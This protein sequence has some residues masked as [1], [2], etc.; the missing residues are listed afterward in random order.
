MQADGHRVSLLDC[1][2][3]A[4]VS[5]ADTRIERADWVGFTATSLTYADARRLRMLITHKPAVIGGVHATLF[6][7]Q[8]LSD[9][10]QLVVVGEGEL[11]M[12]RVHPDCRGILRTVEL[13]DMDA[14]P[15]LPYEL[16]TG[17]HY[18]ATPLHGRNGTT[19]P[20]MSSRGCPWTC[21]FCSKAVFG[22]KF[23]FM[24]PERVV[25]EL[26]WLKRL[27]YREIAFYDDTFTIN[28]QRVA[29]LC[30]LMTPLG[31][32]WTCQARVNTVD[33]ELLRQMK[34]AGCHMIAY[35]I[36]SGVPELLAA[37]SKNITHEQVE[38]AIRLTRQVGIKSLGYFMFGVPGETRDTVEQTIRY[39]LRLDS[40][41]AQFS[42]CTPLPGS[43]LWEKREFA[44]Y[45]GPQTNG[46]CSL[47]LPYLAKSCAQAYMRFYGRPGHIFR[48]LRSWRD[49]QIVASWMNVIRSARK[50]AQ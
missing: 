16:L 26:R 37:I 19:M 22:S 6:P 46:L 9:G 4:T 48:E 8:V 10:F 45:T 39:A 25:E 35:G 50:A 12:R 21:S 44:N 47:S 41:Y 7:G 14:I 32:H 27:G 1:N 24:A 30:D 28:H 23:R 2:A 36:E 33:I 18:R 11:L 40:D 5:M 49:A 15:H 17:Y 43:E 3:G 13:V 38:R 42:M 29:R 20:F 31:L 34:A